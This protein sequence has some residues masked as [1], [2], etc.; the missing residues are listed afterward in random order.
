MPAPA[1]RPAGNGG[2]ERIASSCIRWYSAYGPPVA[3]LHPA[4]DDL[5]V[6]H[7]PARVSHV[8]RHDAQTFRFQL[9]AAL[10]DPR[11]LPPVRERGE[12]QP[13][14]VQVRPHQQYGP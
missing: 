5:E 2:T 13:V 4:V 11:V 12:D 9:T 1:N 3:P 14:A 10:P 7:A 6:G 8:P